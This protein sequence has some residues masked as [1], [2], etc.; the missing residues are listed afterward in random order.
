M[1]SF[2]KQ[3][4]LQIC[5][6]I[7]LSSLHGC[8]SCLTGSGL[9]T[10]LGSSDLRLISTSSSASSALK[11]CHTHFCLHHIVTA[12][13]HHVASLDAMELRLRP[14]PSGRGLQP[15]FRRSESQKLSR[16][17]E[18]EGG[19]NS[20]VTFFTDRPYKPALWWRCGHAPCDATLSRRRRGNTE[21]RNFPSFVQDEPL[22]L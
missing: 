13:P 8:V 17:L 4:R 18:I 6:L 14:G 12:T 20:A 21:K 16:K 5:T 19:R 10:R 3:Q 11:R 9:R 22:P 2:R 15:I 1:Q 7:L